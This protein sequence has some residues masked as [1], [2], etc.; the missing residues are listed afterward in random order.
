M[1]LIDMGLVT[2]QTHH[3]SMNTYSM[4]SPIKCWSKERVCQSEH[5][6]W[7]DV[8]N[9]AEPSA[10]L[11]VGDSEKLPSTVVSC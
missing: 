9:M 11:H 10:A 4:H 5:E 1:E 7:R 6:L 8:A 2:H 3:Q